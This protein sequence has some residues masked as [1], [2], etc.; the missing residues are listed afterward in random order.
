MVTLS[1]NPRAD[2]LSTTPHPYTFCILLK[3]SLQR[4]HPYFSFQSTTTTFRRPLIICFARC[5]GSSW[6]RECS[7]FEKEKKINYYIPFYYKRIMINL[8]RNFRMSIKTSN[9][10]QASWLAVK[11]VLL[12][13]GLESVVCFFFFS[14]LLINT[15]WTII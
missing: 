11:A 13:I 4:T 2:L 3:P 15:T 8:R 10:P 12:I 5:H 14:L 7:V 1:Y 6:T 9:L